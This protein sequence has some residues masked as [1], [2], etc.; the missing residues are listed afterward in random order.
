MNDDKNQKVAKVPP[1][2]GGGV[3]IIIAG[4]GTGGHM[5]PAIGIANAILKQEPKTEI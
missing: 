3:K 4:C 1:L 5:F 2:T